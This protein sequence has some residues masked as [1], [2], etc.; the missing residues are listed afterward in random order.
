M[1]GNIGGPIQG[2]QLPPGSHFPNS[3]PID[4]DA[5]A[6]HSPH[7][8]ASSDKSDPEHSKAPDIAGKDGKTSWRGYSY[9][10]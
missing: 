6:C 1:S 3:R 4:Y 5:Y 8:I 7:E 2:I 10:W 9:D